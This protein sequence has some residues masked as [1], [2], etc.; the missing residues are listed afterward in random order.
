[1]EQL[2]V[3]KT[4]KLLEKN[5]LPFAKSKLA[6]NV[7]QA[8]KV[9][10]DIGYP[11]VLKAISPNI[12]HKSD[13]GA[14]SLSIENEEQL[15]SAFEDLIKK[16]KKAAKN[17]LEGILVQK[18]HTGQE[19]IIGVKQDPTFG[20]VILFGLGGIFVEILKDTSLRIA[21]IEKQDAI[22]MINEL[23]SAKI[24]EG[25]RGQKPVNINAL[26]DI[27]VKTS[28]L[29]ENKKILELDFNP[30]IVDEKSA[31]IVDARIMI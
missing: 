19:V 24:L 11:V 9:A 2:S 23:K 22:E 8:K 6:K 16:T 7:D 14:I 30:I 26:V 18:T 15:E 10:K 20:P 4:V 25:A 21:P 31:V 3:D 12:I 27:L 17:K 5:K 29:A 13:A 1:M 28:K